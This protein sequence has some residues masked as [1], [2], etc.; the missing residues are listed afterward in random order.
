[1]YDSG[2]IY[3]YEH[4]HGE[5]VYPQ[6][7]TKVTPWVM[8][9]VFELGPCEPLIPLLAYPAARHVTYGL[10]ML[11]KCF[12]TFTLLTMTGIVLLGYYGLSVL[13]TSRL[14]RCVPTLG[15]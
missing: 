7:R 10:L 9:I 12:M 15:G 5:I 2:D 3:V 11:I 8:L 6:E 4:K 14:E 13:R 1:V